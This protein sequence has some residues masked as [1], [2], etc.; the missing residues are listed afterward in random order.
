MSMKI[1]KERPRGRS[2][3]RWINN[4]S[5]YLEG[6]RQREGPGYDGSTTPAATWRERDR[7][8]GTG[9][10]GSTTSAATWR[11][12]DREE[13]TGYDGSTTSA[14]TWRERD[15]EEGT[16]YD[17]ST[18][19]AAAWRERDR[20]KAKV[21][22]AQQRQQPPGGKEHQPQRCITNRTVQEP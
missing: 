10:D 1:I 14:A 18:T 19:S 12:R 20:E 2:R 21:K 7:E 22:M 4:I 13:G 8:E 11:E 5:S 3:L 16:G 15:R 17:G 6:E 9:Y